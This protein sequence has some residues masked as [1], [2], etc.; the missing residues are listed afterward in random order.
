MVTNLV[1]KDQVTILIPSHNRHNMLTEGVSWFLR[2]GCKIVVVDSS[3]K[4]WTSQLKS[5]PNITYLH[6]QDTIEKKL[7]LGLEH[8]FTPFVAMCADD[9][10]LFSSGIDKSVEFLSANSEYVFC[11]GIPYQFQNLG[12]RVA[13]WP[14]DYRKDINSNN[15]FERITSLK[16]SCFW[17]V[18]RLETLRLAMNAVG[19][20]EITDKTDIFVGL[21]DEHLSNLLALHGKLK[22][23][24]FPFAFRC[25][26]LTVTSVRSR[27]QLFFDATL[28]EKLTEMVK[29]LTMSKSSTPEHV[30]SVQNS[31]ALNVSAQINYD[32]NVGYGCRPRFL[33]EM[34]ETAV[35]YIELSFRVAKCCFY[36]LKKPRIAIELLRAFDEIRQV[37]NHIKSS[38][39]YQFVRSKSR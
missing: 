3:K 13:F 16:P 4:K 38:I 19:E 9:D 34:P 39:A 31:Y 22:F 33:S 25:Y 30:R 24:C 32:N 10:F 6:V 21:V 12:N 2:M 35:Q 11:Q 20:L 8:V 18:T 27:Y 15:H 7:V 17:G 36:L 5:E 37:S 29:Q 26:S 1:H 14:I 23:D 28:A